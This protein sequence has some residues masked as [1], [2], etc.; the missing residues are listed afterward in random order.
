MLVGTFLCVLF[1]NVLVCFCMLVTLCVILCESVFYMKW[2]VFLCCFCVCEL[3]SV[4]VC[5]SVC[6]LWVRGRFCVLFVFR[7]A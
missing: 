4:P 1:V 7:C 3:L 6:S 5:V 2:L